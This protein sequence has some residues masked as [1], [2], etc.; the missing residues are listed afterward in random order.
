MRPEWP[1]KK[2]LG[3]QPPLLSQDL[4]D[5][6]PPPPLPI[7]RS[8]S[9]SAMSTVAS[10]GLLQWKI[11]KPSVQIKKVMT[12]TNAKPLF[13]RVANRF[14]V[15][16]SVGQRGY[17]CRS[18]NACRP[19]IQRH[20]PRGYLNGLHWE[21]FVLETSPLIIGWGYPR[22]YLVFYVKFMRR[23]NSVNTNIVY[24]SKRF[25]EILHN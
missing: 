8:G 2:F 4:D 23:F 25:V 21:D 14:Y 15:H 9:A 17:G 1:K 10:S 22:N 20:H 6:P 19:C 3:D 12:L 13:K 16:L 5:R 24:F 18:T 11:I 7:W